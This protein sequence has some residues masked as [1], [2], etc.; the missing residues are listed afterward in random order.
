MQVTDEEVVHQITVIHEDG[1]LRT[2]TV[3]EAEFELMEDNREL[4]T[5]EPDERRAQCLIENGG[6]NVTKKIIEEVSL[7][8][9]TLSCITYNSTTHTM[10]D[11]LH[12]NVHRS[13]Q[14]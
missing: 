7:P 8:I 1:F 5:I 14:V 3:N 13:P 2:Y 4:D 12:N 11:L 9:V 10:N 6:E